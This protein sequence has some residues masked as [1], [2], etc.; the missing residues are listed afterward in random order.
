MYAVTRIV[1]VSQMEVSHAFGTLESDLARVCF[2]LRFLPRVPLDCTPHTVIARLV[3]RFDVPSTE[4]TISGTKWT[5]V[6]R[7]RMF[8]TFGV[9]GE[10]RSSE[11]TAS[12]VGMIHVDE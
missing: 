10:T 12:S 4:F 6:E 1:V 9:E 8:A 3:A 5:G 2:A 11:L 7:R